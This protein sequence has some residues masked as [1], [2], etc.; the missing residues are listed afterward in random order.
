MATGY[1]RRIAREGGAGEFHLDRSLYGKLN[2]QA[3]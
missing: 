2:R 3:E 1:Q